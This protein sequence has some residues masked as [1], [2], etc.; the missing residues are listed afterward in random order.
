MTQNFFLLN[1]LP[2]EDE[3]R[4]YHS[5][6]HDFR[7]M[8]ITKDLLAFFDDGEGDFLSR[9][10]CI[11]AFYLIICFWALHFALM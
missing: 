2:G 8:F 5:A 10:F 1:T 7:E 11:K 3:G 4:A 9:N 6:T